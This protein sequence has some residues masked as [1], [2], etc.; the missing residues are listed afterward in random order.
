M[1]RVTVVTGGTEGIGR[2]VAVRLAQ[3]GDRVFIVGRNEER[4]Y[5]V[6][7][8]LRESNPRAEPGFLPADLSL[9]SET[10]RVADELENTTTRL[11][12]VVFCAGVLSTVP[13][14]TVEGL[15]RNF[16]LNYLSR[17]LLARRLLPRLSVAPSGRLVLVSNAGV[18][19]DTLDFSD[20]QHRRG[21]P[22]IQVS[23]RTQFANDLL[24][25]ELADRLDGTRVEVTCVYPGLTRTNVFR[26]ARGLPGIARVLA[27]VI[28][29]VLG[30][31]AE[32]AARTPAFLAQHPD[33][34]GTSGR[35]YGPRLRVRPVPERALRPERQIGLWKLSEE[36][37]RPYLDV[38][39]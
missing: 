8:Q 34:R 31:S 33:A 18:Y 24:V 37:V 25:T 27:P 22:G 39:Q 29:R 11:D 36:L 35:F 28:V 23:G 32:S 12:A 30:S 15:E 7:A 10:S 4:G 2:A 9:L 17:Y 26:N 6:L 13:E 21:K 14:W 38:G 3:G 5:Q 20:L 1:T 19:P 16:V